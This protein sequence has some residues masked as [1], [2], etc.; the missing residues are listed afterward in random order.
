MKYCVHIWKYRKDVRVC[1]ECGKVDI[2]DDG[3]GG[4]GG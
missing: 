4:G 2:D 1:F 3:G